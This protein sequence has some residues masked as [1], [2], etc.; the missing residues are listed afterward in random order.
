MEGKKRLKKEADNCSLVDGRFTNQGNL[1][2][3]LVLGDCKMSTFLHLPVRISKAYIDTLMGFSHVYY[4]MIS[5]TSHSLKAVSWKPAPPVVMVGRRY[6]PKM[7][8][9]GREA[10][11]CLGPAFGLIGSCV[12]S[13]TSSNS[14]RHS[15][16]NGGLHSEPV[17]VIVFG[18]RPFAYVIK[19]L[20]MKSS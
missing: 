15:L 18:K 11:S 13:T 4:P 12:L 10:S 20:E 16:W 2:M 9:R 14:A 5:T 1:H 19:E 6:I 17:N 8:E 7:R 3:R